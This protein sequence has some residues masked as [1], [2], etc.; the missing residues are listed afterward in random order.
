MDLLT[1]GLLGAVLAQAA[2]RRGETRLATGIGFGAGLLADADALIRSS[3]DPLLTLEYHR[4]FSHAL[5]FIPIGA[6]LAALVLW[7]FIRQ[8]LGFARLYLYSLLGYSLSGFLDAC[9]SYG[10]HLF[11]P[12]SQLR[13]AWNI[14]SIIDPVFTLVLLS[15]LLI[16]VG[17]RMSVAARVGLGLAVVY[18]AFGWLQHERAEL[19]A[20]ELARQRGHGVARM[21]VKPTL[22]NLLL[23]RSVYVSGDRFHVDAIRVGPGSGVRVYGGG[24]L[25]R[26]TPRG[27]L[28]RLAADTVLY[29][30][31]QRF[32]E[33]SDDYLVRYPGKPRVLGDVRYA[34][35]PNGL[36]P[37]WGIHMDP[38]APERHAEYQVY[39]D[40][41]KE[42][43]RR[44][45][46]MLLG[47]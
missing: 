14:I 31:I 28:P 33:F 26:F 16:G 10:T 24:S 29:R 35:L 18:L 21:V 9:T 22:G 39:R 1:Q 23:W 43:R 42:N 40:A 5:V 37:L 27:D 12:F 13:T 34:M 36:E 3:G 46:D 4:H 41:S 45:V 11:W 17:K 7:P 15:A 20:A 25:E 44:F 6:L 19:A 30:D 47:R 8:R 2:S 38:E 32:R